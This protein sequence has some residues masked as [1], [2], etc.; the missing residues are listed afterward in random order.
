MAETTDG[1][2]LLAVRLR[3][4]RPCRTSGKTLDNIVC[5]CE[6]GSCPSKACRR[7]D[8]AWADWVE[9]EPCSRAWIQ[10]GTP[11]ALWRRK[12]RGGV[13]TRSVYLKITHCLFRGVVWGYLL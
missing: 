13:K 6:L 4:P 3:E 7:L 8:S 10:A 9:L 2:E 12:G 1:V 11:A 5:S